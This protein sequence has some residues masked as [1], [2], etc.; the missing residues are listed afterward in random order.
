MSKTKQKEL[1]ENELAAWLNKANTSIEPYSKPIAAVVGLLIVGLIA[2]G[3]YSGKAAGDRSDA[4]LQ[5][6]M[7]DPEVADRYPETAAAAW[8]TLYSANSDLEAGIQ[9]LYTNR[10]DAETLLT[11][12]KE[13]FNTAVD[14]SDDVL[15]RSR[16]Y[17]GIALASES[18]GQLDEAIEAYKNCIDVNESEAMVSKAQA[19]ID[20]L[21]NPDTQ[22]FVAWFGEQDFA[23]ADPS[24][25]PELPG[26]VTLPELPDLKLSPLLSDEKDGEK[27]DD[28]M[29]LDDLP[30]DLDL[31]AD[32]DQGAKSD[33]DAKSDDSADKKE[34][35]ELP[36]TDK[37]EKKE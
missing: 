13:T 10:E 5:L 25:P 26:D 33:G 18:L 11:Q 14:S 3:L 37:P 9:A 7:S 30:S 27:G 36:T 22:E 32:G 4:T 21:T 20:E 12:A 6:L 17:L 29:K 15:L 8:S 24:L 35:L 16:A 34:G 19:R 28:E 1:N 23:P 31:P 2:W